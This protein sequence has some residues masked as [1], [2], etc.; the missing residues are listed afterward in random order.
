MNQI[1]LTSWYI[2]CKIGFGC[3]FFSSAPNSSRHCP[4]SSI[5]EHTIRHIPILFSSKTTFSL[6]Q[7]RLFLF[8]ILSLFYSFTLS[9]SYAN[10]IIIFEKHF[11][12]Q[13]IQF[14]QKAKEIQALQNTNSFITSFIS[15]LPLDKACHELKKIKSPDCNTPI[16]KLLVL[17]NTF[18]ALEGIILEI[19]NLSNINIS[20]VSQNHIRRNSNSGSFRTR[21]L[22]ITKLSPTRR[23]IQSISTKIEQSSSNSRVD[24]SKKIRSHVMDLALLLLLYYIPSNFRAQLEFIRLH[25]I[26]DEFYSVLAIY[27]EIFQSS[28]NYILHFTHTSESKRHNTFICGRVTEDIVEMLPVSLGVHHRVTTVDCGKHHFCIL[29]TGK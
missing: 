27:Y 22:S 21:K 16:S 5:L 17:K 23:R 9:L 19:P 4:V 8:T 2:L 1:H 6:F 29:L 15:K 24:R 12:E 14:Q 10:L 13:E 3:K 26:N 25:S 11:Q 28:Y 7:I 18:I 20:V